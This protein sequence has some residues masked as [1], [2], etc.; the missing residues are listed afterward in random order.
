VQ[1]YKGWFRTRGSKEVEHQNVL[2]QAPEQPPVPD[3]GL[4]TAGSTMA[5]LRALNEPQLPGGVGGSA[6]DFNRLAPVPDTQV[7]SSP[8]RALE[9]VRNPQGVSPLPD[10]SPAPTN[11]TATSGAAQLPPGGITQDQWE[12]LIQ[13]A[14]AGPPKRTR[15]EAEEFLRSP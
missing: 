8:E 12:G 5:N 6:S 15:A 14:I 3:I 1:Q 9:S 2:Y 13:Q 10:T 4:G 7:D 11:T